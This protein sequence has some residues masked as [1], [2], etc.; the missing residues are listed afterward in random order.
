[1]A[2]LPDYEGH[3]SH[4]LGHSSDE[5]IERFIKGYHNLKHD[6]KRVHNPLALL[7]NCFLAKS[8]AEWIQTGDLNEVKRIVFAADKCDRMSSQ[9]RVGSDGIGLDRAYAALLSDNP[10]SLHWRKWDM[11]PVMRQSKGRAPEF[12]QPQSGTY[13][14]FNCHLAMM[15]E[16]E[17]LKER[18][19]TV[20]KLL[21]DGQIKL[22]QG[23]SYKF[24][25]QYFV[26]LADG[27]RAG[28]EANINELLKGRTAYTRNNEDGFGYQC[29]VVSGCGFM[30][31][32]IAYIHGYEL[33]IDSPWVP[34]EWLPVKPLDHY[35]TG[36]DF[37]DE[38]DM[39]TPFG[40]NT[41]RFKNAI[42]LSPI[43]PDKPQIPIR[44]WVERVERG[45]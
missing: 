7:R 18:S 38:F 31:T 12:M 10:E 33:N 20:L 44:E 30:L 16:F 5:R 40:Q 15:G 6:P 35:E 23:K 41:D 25:H 34:K 24:D 3:L 27:D 45:Y 11:L 14:A 39:F 19:E 28:M 43:A 9:Y 32:K 13:Y 22:H 37:I 42:E 36:I 29:K 2:Y 8:L 4:L 17:W 1:M 21:E 26:A